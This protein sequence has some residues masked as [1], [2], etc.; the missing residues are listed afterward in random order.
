MM[1]VV[2]GWPVSS[3]S[4]N[5]QRWVTSGVVYRKPLGRSWNGSAAEGRA[6]V[7]LWCDRITMDL[8]RAFDRS[9]TP[10]PGGET[11]LP[12]G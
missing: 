7:M 11:Q 1:P 3:P 9:Q 12:C 2:V 4:S 8:D 10:L 6:R 5:L